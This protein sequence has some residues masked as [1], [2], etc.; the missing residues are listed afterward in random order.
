[1]QQMYGIDAEQHNLLYKENI[2]RLDKNIEKERDY[3]QIFNKKFKTKI[4]Q[5]EYFSL[6]RRHI[7]V[8][9]KL[10]NTLDTLGNVHICIVSDN[11]LGL[12]TGF[13]AIFGNSFKRYK[14]FYSFKLKS[15][16]AEGMLAMV[17]KKI[18]AQPDECLFIDDSEKNIFAAKKLNMNTLLFK[19]NE[20]LFSEF[21]KYFPEYSH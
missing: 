7:K 6:F 3:I 2:N 10:M 21:Y 20:E 19:T 16:K 5:K 18:N 12:C 4:S 14:K 1:M 13:N 8:N 11:F 9:T 15:T 17:V